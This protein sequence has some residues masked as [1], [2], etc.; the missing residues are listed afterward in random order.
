MTL[1]AGCHSGSN[2]GGTAAGTTGGSTGGGDHTQLAFVTNNASD[3]WTIC[4]KGTEAAAKD[5]GNVDVQFI[6]PSDGSAAT[7][8]Q[9]VNDLLAKGVKGIAISPVDPLNETPFLNTVASKTN[10]ITSDSDAAKSDRL[11]YIGTDNHAAGVMAGRLIRKAL[12]LGGQVMLFVGRRD[13]QNASDRIAGI[14]DA[15]RGSRSTILGVQTD[16]ADHAR[17]RKNVVDT[18]VRH[19]HVAAL[20]GIWSYNG[21]AIYSV[22]QGAGKVKIIAFDEESDTLNGIQAGA[23]YGT[24][25]QQPYR[26]G[27]ESV[28]LL[29]AL[30][31]G[32]KRGIPAGRRLVIPTVAVMRANL[33]AYQAQHKKQLAG[34]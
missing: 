4:R 3:Y 26:L 31:R 32:D 10:L 17:A 5:L 25:A 30:V 19:P 23:I 24:I 7:Q 22:V 1:L 6:M 27:Y 16:D 2:S 34:D 29:A 8:T 28:K 9:D 20:V 14:R 11:C 33:G 15:L 21:P 12:P 13:A 18:L